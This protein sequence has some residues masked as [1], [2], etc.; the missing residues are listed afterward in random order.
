MN[1]NRL[2]WNRKALILNLF[3]KYE[4]IIQVN[5]NEYKFSL[6]ARVNAAT[7]GTILFL[8][9]SPNVPLIQLL[10]KNRL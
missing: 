7:H 9:Q 2:V 6:N 5:D 10:G 3:K 1:F 4:Y 8:F